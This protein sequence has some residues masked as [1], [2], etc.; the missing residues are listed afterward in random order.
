[1]IDGLRAIA[2]TGIKRLIRR[3]FAEVQTVSTQTLKRWLDQDPNSV[4]LWDARSLEEYAVSHLP[5]AQL[6]PLTIAEVRSKGVAQLEQLGSVPIV[7]YCSV[8][9]RSARLIHEI[10]TLKP[11]EMYN[12]EGSL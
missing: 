12:L 3:R 1:M 10:Q 9:Y 7:V 4:M 2:M 8:G 11:V 6:A 5:N